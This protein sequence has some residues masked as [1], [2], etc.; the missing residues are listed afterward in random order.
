MV[1]IIE[2]EE[3]QLALSFDHGDLVWKCSIV[4]GDNIKI[5][6]NSK[7]DSQLHPYHK[8]ILFNLEEAEMII[9]IIRTAMEIARKNRKIL[10]S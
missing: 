4:D 5:E 1:K 7:P 3:I 2:S 10:G 6:E 9:Q 8:D